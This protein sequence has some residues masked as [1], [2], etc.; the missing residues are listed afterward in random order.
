MLALAEASAGMGAW[1]IDLA[2]GLL[3]G[4]AR[5]FRIM[6]LASDNG[7]GADRNHTQPA[8]SGRSR[9]CPA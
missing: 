2:T 3:R 9:S 5:F 4:T 1:D 7:A 8:P 6:G